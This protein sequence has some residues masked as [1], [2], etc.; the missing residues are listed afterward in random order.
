MPVV[1]AICKLLGTG[2]R[3]Q[4]VAL[5]D[6]HDRIAPNQARARN[7]GRASVCSGMR[8]GPFAATGSAD[9]VEISLA[10]CA[11]DFCI[12]QLTFFA[13]CQCCAEVKAAITNSRRAN[14]LRGNNIFGAANDR[15]GSKQ[16]SS[17]K[18]KE[19]RGNTGIFGDDGVGGRPTTPSVRVSQPAGG[20]STITFG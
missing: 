17:N 4:S 11:V 8:Q 18:A 20:R 3:E 16:V 1:H 12:W 19:L 15:P 9:G 7:R 5:I 13:A 10:E 14:E 2:N 6:M